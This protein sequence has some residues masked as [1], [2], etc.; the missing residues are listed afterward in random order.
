[1]L[2]FFHKS[3]ELPSVNYAALSDTRKI[4]TNES[5]SANAINSNAFILINDITN[6]IR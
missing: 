1:M 4:N 2:Y 5:I 6:D 3:T